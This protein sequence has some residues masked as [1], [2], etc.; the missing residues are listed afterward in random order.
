MTSTCS[1][2]RLWDCSTADMLRHIFFSPPLQVPASALVQER[3]RRRRDAGIPLGAAET[4][5]DTSDEAVLQRL[6]VSA[7]PQ[8]S[9]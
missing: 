6:R 2:Q 7:Q 9:A 8:C 5:A 3:R 4:E 1:S